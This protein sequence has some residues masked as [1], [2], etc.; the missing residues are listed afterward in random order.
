M[1]KNKKEKPEV[2]VILMHKGFMPEVYSAVYNVDRK[3]KSNT[4]YSI[5]WQCSSCGLSVTEGSHKVKIGENFKIKC[6]A[7]GTEYNAWILKRV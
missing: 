1:K 7:C 4:G 6:D 2:F 5:F 3:F